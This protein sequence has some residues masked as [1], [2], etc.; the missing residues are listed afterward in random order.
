MNRGDLIGAK[1]NGAAAGSCSRCGIA[2]MGNRSLCDDC[3]PVVSPGFFPSV[4]VSLA[5][6]II[7]L[8]VIFEVLVK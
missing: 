4:A 8:V 2:T 1:S 6:L 5:L 7:A 3:A